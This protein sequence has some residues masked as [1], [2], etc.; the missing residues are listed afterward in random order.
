M[1]HRARVED[2]E[3]VGGHR[4]RA[5]DDQRIHI[6]LG[7]LRMVLGD[8]LE[9]ADGANQR[10]AIHGRHTAKVVEQRVCSDSGE[11]LLDIPA[12]QG[13][14]AERDVLVRLGE[15]AADAEED[16]GAKERVALHPDH[17]L[18][19][20]AHHPLDEQAGVLSFG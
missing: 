19:W 2:H 9:R 15:D 1:P 14:Y 5:L 12:P 20:P 7:D 16:H 11:H 8:P 3:C 10:R 6:D 4:R 13:R 17:E 18:A